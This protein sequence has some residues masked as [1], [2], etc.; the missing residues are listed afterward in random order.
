[1]APLS[2]TSVLCSGSMK[3]PIIGIGTW[4]GSNDEVLVAVDAALEAGY[5]H[6]DTAHVYF[7]ET[8]I[9]SVLKKWFDSG[10]LK[11][12]EVFIVTKVNP[13]HLRP[14]HIEKSLDESLERLGLEYVDLFIFH[15]PV[16]WK[17]TE[18]GK[19][20]LEDGV[21][22]VDMKTDHVAC[23]KV[24]ETMVDKGKTKSIGV[25]NF[26]LNQVKRL[27]EV[28]RIKPV[29]NQVELHVYFQQKELVE[30][31]KK[32]GVVTCA[33]GPI[34]SPGLE[35]FNERVGG[36][37]P[38]HEYLHPMEDPVVL[39][40]A[41][42]YGKTPAQVLLRHLVQ[43]GIGVIPKSSNPKRVKENI[44]IFDFEL[45]PEEYEKMKALDK[46][47]AG[48]QFKRGGMFSSMSK[49]P[50]FHIPNMP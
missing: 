48:R 35:K 44:D 22:A 32:N 16:G 24:M 36:Q 47:E 45:T 17:Y 49:H 14:E 21:L 6:I 39:E 2:P 28:G 42:K 19:M 7:N 34:G 1:M 43:Y 8:G 11:R 13:S 30:F 41:K 37:L 27:L 31:S 3:M 38:G 23:W 40:I 10:K 12:E 26:T 20:P 4:Q 5:R 50:E 9:G 18:D 33:Y 25:S 15:N 29:Y 46:G